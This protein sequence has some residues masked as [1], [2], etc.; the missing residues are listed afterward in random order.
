[1]PESG[2]V[3]REP[4]QSSLL[5]PLHPAT[6]ESAGKGRPA[7]AKELNSAFAKQPAVRFDG[8]AVTAT[9]GWGVSLGHRGCFFV[10]VDAGAAGGECYR[11][12]CA[13]C[14]GAATMLVRCGSVPG[15]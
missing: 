7:T 12:I 13:S 2:A 4:W 3:P 8:D 1:L 9:H 10:P 11:R 5:L 15:L 6:A 14:A